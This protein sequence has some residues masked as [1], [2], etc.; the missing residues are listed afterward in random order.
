MGIVTVMLVAVV[1]VSSN[2]GNP[3]HPNHS[4][5]SKVNYLP[6]ELQPLAQEFLKNDREIRNKTIVYN[7]MKK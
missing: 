6:K 7:D 1:T 3:L 5:D 4:L 2:A